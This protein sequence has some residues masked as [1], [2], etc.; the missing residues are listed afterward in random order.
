MPRRFALLLVLTAGSPAAAQNA[1][2]DGRMLE[3]RQEVTAPRDRG[4]GDRF[5]QEIRFRNAI[6]TG[7]APGGL[8]FRGDVGYVGAGE[9]AGS[10]G[11]GAAGIEGLGAGT[12]LGSNDIFP[13]RRD[14]YYSGLSGYGLRGT[15]ALQY[16]FSLTTGAAPPEGLIGTPTLQR[17][18]SGRLGGEV[19]TE[20]PGTP[21]LDSQLI[22]LD[23]LELE[24]PQRLEFEHESGGRLR[25]SL[26]SSLR[27][28]SSYS[29]MRQLQPVL[30]EAGESEDGERFGMIASPLQ[31]VQITPLAQR[32]AEEDAEREAR[33]RRDPRQGRGPRTLDERLD[34]ARGPELASRPLV[35]AHDQFINTLYEDFESRRLG[36]EEDARD[37]MGLPAAPGAGDDPLGRSPMPG[38]LSTFE[39][40]LEALRED[41]RRLRE[42][43]QQ[44]EGAAGRDQMPP[45][46]EEA[47]ER[48]AQ[49]ELYEVLRR[50][51]GNVDSLMLPEVDPSYDPF[52]D[53]MRAAERLLGEGRFFDAE[54]RYTRALS[55][56]PADVSA[57]VGRVHSQLGAGMLISAATNL[58]ALLMGHPEV[59]AM[60][61]G[62]DLLPAEERQERLIALLR[63]NARSAEGEGAER[64]ARES[65]LLLAYLGHQRRDP[66]LVREGL[67][68]FGE[69]ERPA[70]EALRALLR[71]VWLEDQGARDG[72]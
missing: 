52:A 47:D 72:G 48:D 49:Q 50:T 3:Y 71:G 43:P 32:R 39:D 38:Q 61:Y 15:E 70:D 60:R 68:A 64:L 23:P 56:R 53:H 45:L 65:G 6:V 19:L 29:T 33:E 14:T 18:G 35:T 5:M 63:S 10:L 51:G 69:S 58:R 66:S 12:G 67:E 17:A 40:R 4:A 62:P 42:G 44:R 54:E 9:F 46:P 36:R 27:T 1:L 7:N 11:L 41:L 57:Q 13:Y 16:Q 59:A 55:A 24:R 8:S 25:G 31:G 2:G 37:A 30:L 22:E 28:T 21:L 34:D 20:R 26:L